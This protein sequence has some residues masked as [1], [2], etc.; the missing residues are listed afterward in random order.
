[1]RENSRDDPCPEPM[2]VLNDALNI[3]TWIDRRCASGSCVY[4]K[5]NIVGHATCKLVE[6]TGVYIIRPVLR[7]R[8]RQL[9]PTQQLMHFDVGITKPRQ[10]RHSVDGPACPHLT[11]CSVLDDG[12]NLRSQLVHSLPGRGWLALALL[13]QLVALSEWFV[14]DVSVC[15]CKQ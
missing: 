10:N 4:D 14:R 1:M 7:R 5:I 12:N 13:A 9:T 3:P 11:C 15:L 8:A 2:R 6:Q